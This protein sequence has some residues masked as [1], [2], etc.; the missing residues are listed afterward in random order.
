MNRHL[1]P[2]IDSVLPQPHSL[3]ALRNPHMLDPRLSSPSSGLTTPNSGHQLPGL[4]RSQRHNTR[5]FPD[6]HQLNPIQ[7]P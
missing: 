5:S 7:Y 1:Q 4:V 2:R 3:C 6:R